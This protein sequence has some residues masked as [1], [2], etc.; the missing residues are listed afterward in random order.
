MRITRSNYESWFLDFL[1]GN[2][3]PSL[4]EEL[5]SFIKQNP[6]LA[7]ELEMWD[8]ITLQASKSIQFDV[9][10]ELK[11]PV[12]DQDIEFQELAV[13]YH[14]GDLSLSERINFEAGLSENP[15]RAADAEKFGKL[16]LTADKSIVYPN[17]EQLKRRVTILPLW[18]K[19]AS[20]AALLLAAYLLFHPGAGVRTESAQL[21]DDLNNPGRK[22][23]TVPELKI[24]AEDKGKAK[25]SPLVTPVQIPAKVPMRQKQQPARQKSVGKG[26][27]TPYLRVPEQQ[28]SRLKPRGI[29]NF[30]M[31]ARIELAVMTFKDPAQ[32]STELELSELLKVQIAE[33]RKSDDREFLSTEHLGLSGLQ[34]FAKLSR[35]RLTARKGNDWNVHSVSYNSRL[36]AFSIPVNR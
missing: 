35:K 28:P 31:P 25:T 22:N 21:V 30:G 16:K 8:L 5:Q 20:A 3:A 19:V 4:T 36:L 12:N 9:K 18:I 32:A 17:K 2:L 33:M 7:K 27:P 15:G 23:I 11:K 29:I 26:L 10:E 34:L 6:D 1:E 13:A 14:E 24:K